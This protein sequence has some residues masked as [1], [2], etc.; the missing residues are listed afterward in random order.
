MCDE[1]LA[2][3]IRAHK[4]AAA[5]HER[6]A[7]LHERAALQAASVVDLPRQ[8]RELALATAQHGFAALKRERQHAVEEQFRAA[9]TEGH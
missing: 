5:T 1:R 4:R 2:R 7:R 9:L 8:D 3:R 6:A